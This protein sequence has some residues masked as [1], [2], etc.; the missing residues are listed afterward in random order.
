MKGNGIA[1]VNTVADYCGEQNAYCAC[2][3]ATVNAFGGRFED[4]F[5]VI[6]F[7]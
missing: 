5:L 7:L 6:S 2:P 3:I 4:L 1:V